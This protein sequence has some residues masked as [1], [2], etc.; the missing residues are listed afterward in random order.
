MLSLA[1]GR[2]PE[3]LAAWSVLRPRR[4]DTRLAAAALG[5]ATQARTV[6]HANVAVQV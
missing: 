5:V 6:P 1:R 4:Y 3:R 2:W